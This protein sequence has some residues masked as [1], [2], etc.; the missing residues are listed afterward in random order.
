MSCVQYEHEGRQADDRLPLG[1]RKVFE[2]LWGISAGYI[3]FALCEICAGRF[4]RIA[5]LTFQNG[6]NVNP[7][8]V[9]HSCRRCLRRV[10]EVSDGGNRVAFVSKWNFQSRAVNV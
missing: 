3:S 2:I 8:Y 10:S 4:L 6:F 5:A 9:G 7:I 1:Q